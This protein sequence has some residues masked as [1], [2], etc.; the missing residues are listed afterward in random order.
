MKSHTFVSV[1]VL[2]LIAT[3]ELK[4]TIVSI[5]FNSRGKFGTYIRGHLTED[6]KA[7]VVDRTRYTWVRIGQDDKNPEWRAASIGP[8]DSYDF[9]ISNGNHYGNGT[10]VTIVQIIFHEGIGRTNIRPCFQR[11]STKC[12]RVFTFAHRMCGDIKN[13]AYSDWTKENNGVPPTEAGWAAV[14]PW[15]NGCYCKLGVCGWSELAG[16]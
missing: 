16:S 8:A 5:D 13:K 9:I 11:I 7:V 10:E 1:L 15:V 2:T 6:K 14:S 4:S 12:S 3:V